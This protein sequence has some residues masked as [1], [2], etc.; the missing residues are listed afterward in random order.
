MFI[1]GLVYNNLLNLWFGISKRC[2]LCCCSYKLL[3]KEKE[4]LEAEFLQYRREMKNTSTG[5][6]VKDLRTMKQVMKNLEEEL[7]KEKTRHQRSAS[8]RGQEY[9]DLLEEVIVICVILVLVLQWNLFKEVIVTMLILLLQEMIV[10]C[11][12]FWCLLCEKK[13]E[14]RCALI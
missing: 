14:K 9:R 6:A 13:T 5:T 7:M 11:N 8:K 12:C 3:L 1:P 4:E 2:K 10:M